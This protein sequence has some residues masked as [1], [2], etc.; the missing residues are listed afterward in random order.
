MLGWGQMVQ[1]HLETQVALLH[2]ELV[3]EEM[4]ERQ[5]L[6]AVAVAVQAQ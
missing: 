3:L 6:T 4:A 1:I 2:L 5:T